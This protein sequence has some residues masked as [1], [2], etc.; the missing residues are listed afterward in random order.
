[1]LNEL[2]YIHSRCF[3]FRQVYIEKFALWKF[4]FYYLAESVVSP[5]LLF[6]SKGK[7]KQ[8]INFKGAVNLALTIS[9]KTELLVQHGHRSTDLGSA[10][11]TDMGHHR[12]QRK[13]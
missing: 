10:V 9:N 5:S 12:L 13:D 11:S 2:C 7:G 1:M 8:D 3:C 6:L 4:D